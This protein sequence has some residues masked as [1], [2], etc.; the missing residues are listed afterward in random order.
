VERRSFLVSIGSAAAGVPGFA[1][2]IRYYAVERFDRLPRTGKRPA[3]IL[4]ALVAPRL[5]EVRV[6]HEA[7]RPSE[8]CLAVWAES[9]APATGILEWRVY[10]TAMF[11]E[12]RCAGIHPVLSATR[13]DGA[14]EYIYVIP[15]P[16]LTARQEGW[17]AFGVRRAAPIHLSI[18]KVAG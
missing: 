3:F 11:G 15:F 9:P 17:A 5:P 14:R 12:F 7:V 8:A 13:A 2:P 16:D 6:F 4:E 10:R 1:A 18:W